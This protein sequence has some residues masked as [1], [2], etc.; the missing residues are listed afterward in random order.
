MF[1]LFLRFIGGVL[2]RGVPC[3]LRY[4]AVGMQ[5]Q[6]SACLACPRRRTPRVGVQGHGTRRR[7]TF[8]LAIILVAG[9]ANAAKTADDAPTQSVGIEQGALS[10]IFRDNSKSPRVLSGVDALFNTDVA[11][12]FD[13]FDPVGRGA[14]AGLNF[15]HIISGHANPA[16]MFTPQH[17]KYDLRRLSG[18]ASVQLVRRAEDEPWKVASTFTSAAATAFRALP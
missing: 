13:A 12:G 15:E 3:L 8:V 14:S 1:R 10:A 6:I 2:N 17:G 18:G 4:S 16:N 7:L 11:P 5:N 9:L